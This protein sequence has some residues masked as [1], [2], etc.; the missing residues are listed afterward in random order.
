M[1]FYF[2]SPLL[3]VG[4]AAVFTTARS[5]V[6][7]RCFL[8]R[9]CPHFSFTLSQFLTLD[10]Q[11]Y[12]SLMALLFFFA[13]FFNGTFIKTSLSFSIHAVREVRHENVT[14]ISQAVH[15][16]RKSRMVKEE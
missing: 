8:H 14:P 9:L 11:I 4:R 3:S 16:K 15:G 1:W 10:T 13:P 5:P 12:L 2:T 7:R 6:N